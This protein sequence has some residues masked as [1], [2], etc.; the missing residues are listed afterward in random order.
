MGLVKKTPASKLVVSL[1]EAKVQLELAD[2][3]M[4]HDF[5]LEMLIK[6]A[7]NQIE[8]RTDRSLL[9]QTFVLALNRFPCFE[10]ELP[11][12]PLVSVTSIKYVDDSGV[13][14]TL[15]SAEYKVGTN[16]HPGRV[17]P[18]Y[19]D[20]W[21]VARN[22]IEAVQIEYIAGYGEEPC[23]VPDEFRMAILLTV[24]HWFDPDSPVGKH[25]SAGIPGAAMQLIDSLHSGM[26]Y[27]AY[28]IT[29]DVHTETRFSER[30]N[31]N[32]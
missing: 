15:D 10:V 32:Y 13:Q 19:G 3:E 6:A 16:S 8:Q 31:L 25:E 5:H 26:K 29:Q 11:Y 4:D 20:T 22:E 28:N 14:Q 23:N 18:I 27:G 12:P 7:T 30:R 17:T 21:P 2:V 9:N 1:E 24:D